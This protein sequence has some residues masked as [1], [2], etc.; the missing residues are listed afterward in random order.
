[1]NKIDD[2][3]LCDILI[4]EAVIELLSDKARISRRALLTKL[5]AMLEGEKDESRRRATKLAIREVRSE[6][7]SDDALRGGDRNNVVSFMRNERSDDDQTR[8]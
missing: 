2:E 7:N 4:G 6:M 8:H 5:Q 1:M 3:K